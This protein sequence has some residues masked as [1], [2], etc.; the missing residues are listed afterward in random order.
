MEIT[1]A[2]RAFP[3]TFGNSLLPVCPHV[4]VGRSWAAR[5]GA[6]AQRHRRIT[7]LLIARQGAIEKASPTHRQRQQA[8][9]HRPGAN[10]KFVH[11]HRRL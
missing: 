3:P 4:H 7:M 10:L 8:V 11:F 1:R 2:S 9:V 5:V 6:R